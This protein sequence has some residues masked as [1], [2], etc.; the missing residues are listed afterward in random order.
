MLL[1]RAA[2]SPIARMGSVLGPETYVAAS[3]LSTLTTLGL[4]A[5]LQICLDAGE[6]DSYTSGQTWLDL[7]ANDRDFFLGADNAATASDPTFNGVADALSSAEFFSF[8]GGDYFTKATANDTFINSLH[9]DNAAFTLA[10]WVRPATSSIDPFF[11]T[12]AN[13]ETNVGIT[14]FYEGL[15]GTAVLNVSKGSAGYAAQ[16]GASLGVTN[17]AWQF[18]A[19]SVN[20]AGTFFWQRNASA[21]T[22]ASAAY[23]S[24]S[25]AAA[26]NTAV[27]GDIGG[28]AFPVPS[29][30][31]IAIFMAFDAAL[32]QW[33]LE[34]IYNKTRRRFGV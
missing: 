19:V 27:I 16:L 4:T 10:F 24:P 14:G 33:Q 7:T 30:T 13:T 32:T 5:N 2:L 15:T 22:P 28:G 31:R 34:Q 3:L 12:A 26:T 6:G 29:G 1:P 8:D 18:I 9:K 21:S 20:E 23:T 17:G 11:G 25:A